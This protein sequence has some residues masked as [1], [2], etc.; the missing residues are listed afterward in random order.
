MRFLFG[1]T[2]GLMPLPRLM[3]LQLG[4]WDS[5]VC[6][7]FVQESEKKAMST[8]WWRGFQNMARSLLCDLICYRSFQNS[9]RLLV[10]ISI[11]YLSTNMFVAW[12]GWNQ[13]NTFFLGSFFGFCQ[14]LYQRMSL[15]EWF[16]IKQTTFAL[17]SVWTLEEWN[18]ESGFYLGLIWA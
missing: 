2:T 17:R 14:A 3:V 18:I 9:Q 8:S 15:L 1:A 16:C 4:C 12:L 10:Q 5:G 6:I 13:L 7:F 11:L